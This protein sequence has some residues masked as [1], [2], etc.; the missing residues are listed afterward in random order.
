MPRKM[1]ETLDTF[2]SQHGQNLWDMTFHK[3]FNCSSLNSYCLNFCHLI[4]LQ[5]ETSTCCILL[6]GKC[7]VRSAHS[8]CFIKYQQQRVWIQ[9]NTRSFRFYLQFLF[10][11]PYVISS[12]YALVWILLSHEITNTIHLYL[13]LHCGT[14]GYESFSK[15][16]YIYSVVP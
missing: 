12:N 3:C 4:I 10:H 15:A 6:G 13:W 11:N 9:T 16:K 14:K 8:N 7:C 2:S 5:Q 1:L